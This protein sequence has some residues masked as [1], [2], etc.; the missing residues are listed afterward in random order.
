MEKKSEAGATK[1]LAC[2]SDLLE[3]KKHKKIV[4]LL[5]YFR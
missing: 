4:L 2:S 3:D 1:K 5:L